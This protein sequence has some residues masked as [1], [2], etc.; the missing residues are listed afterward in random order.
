MNKKKIIIIT[1][2]VIL[3]VVAILFIFLGNKEYRVSFDGVDGSVVEIQK[4]GKNRFIKKPKD[5]VK[6]GYTFEGWYLDG[7]LFDFNTPITKNIEL[8]AKW[9]P[10]DS[11]DE[12]EKLEVSF[13]TDGGSSIASIKVEKN[14]KINKPTDPIKEGHKFISW[15][16]DGKDFDFSTLITKSIELVAKWEKETIQNDTPNIIPISNI[17]LSKTSISLYVGGKF[18][19]TATIKPNNATNKNI[20]WKSSNSSVATVDSKGNVIAKGVGKVTI[21]ATSGG[22][23]ATCTIIVNKKITYSVKWVEVSG[24]SIGQYMLHI[25]SSDGK[26]VA[27]KVLVTAIDES[28]E[29]V[30][31]PTTGK[32]YIKSAIKSAIVKSIN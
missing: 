2:I 25:Q 28:T 7:E 29:I 13:D 8:I 26:Y 17:T 5:P 30:D 32:M 31:I 22:K 15:Q 27:G 19:L 9:I 20:T 24:S 3:I 11:I 23:K 21:T 10:I 14:E 16:L 18:K 12:T 4:V 6:E 1:V